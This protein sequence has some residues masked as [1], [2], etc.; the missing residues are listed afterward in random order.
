MKATTKKGA[1]LVV[2]A[3][4]P[5][6]QRVARSERVKVFEAEPYGWIARSE[7]AAGERDYHLFCEPQTKR[8]AC[9]CADFVYRGNAEHGYECKHVSAVLRF[10]AREYLAHEYDPQ[11]QQ[12]QRRPRAA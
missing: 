3:F 1:A 4:T 8:L 11:R 9:T 10:I 6:E 12:R 7:S 5:A 2:H